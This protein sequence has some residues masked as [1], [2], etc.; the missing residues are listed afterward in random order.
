MDPLAT[1][2]TIAFAG[3]WH[4]NNNWSVSAAR[5]AS[6]NG[7]DV[8]LHLGDFG[9][10]FTPRYLDGLNEVLRELNIPLL[11]V[12]GN[13]ENF[14]V[15]YGEYSIGDN[16][17]RQLR[18]FIWHIPR[19]FRWTWDGVQFLGVGGA[20]SI[21]RPYRTLGQS[22]WH[23]EQISDVDVE[24]AIAGGP[25]D[26]LLSHDCPS[27]VE[28]PGIV[29]NSRMWN[30]VELHTSK[31]HQVQLRRI[32]DV[33]Q[34]KLMWH[35]HFHTRYQTSVD[36]GYGPVTVTGLDCDAS[37]LT[38]NMHMVPLLDLQLHVEGWH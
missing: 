28:I 11:F 8:I 38:L 9:Y 30:P 34:P 14:D 24:T 33:V 32:V 19:G 17:L 29:E 37:E 7:A 20:H 18:D 1:P 23:Q 3:D 22:W 6:D 13:H 16:G 5:Y 31:L 27:G 4:A 2:S 35:G 25:A 10:W 12:D 26:V 36:L 21:D 15:L